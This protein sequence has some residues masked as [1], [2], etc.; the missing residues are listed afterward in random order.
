MAHAGRE[1]YV[2]EV[3]E[4]FYDEKFPEDT[5]RLDLPGVEFKRA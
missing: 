3:T 4:I 1:F 5:F 2:A